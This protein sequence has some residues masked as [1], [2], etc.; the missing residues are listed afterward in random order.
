MKLTHRKTRGKTK[1]SP[2]QYLEAL[3][4]LLRK[5]YFT[6]QYR[7]GLLSYKKIAEFIIQRKAEKAM[8]F[9]KLNSKLAPTLAITRALI[10]DFPQI[11]FKISTQTS[12]NEGA[13]L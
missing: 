4:F 1:L 12:H 7:T 2:F 6:V 9:F 8:I 10:Y 11:K 5:L 13:N 3:L